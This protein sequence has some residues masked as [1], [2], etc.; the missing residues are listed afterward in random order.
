MTK[1]IKYLYQ[2]KADICIYFDWFNQDFDPETDRYF[3]YEERGGKYVDYE[4]AGTVYW[5][6]HEVV[7]KGLFNWWYSIM[8][9]TSA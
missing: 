3:V 1:F 2:K 7:G 9:D 4:C 8:G 5:F 6:E